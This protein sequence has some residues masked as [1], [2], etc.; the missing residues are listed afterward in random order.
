MPNNKTYTIAANATAQ[1]DIKDDFGAND[2]TT[3]RIKLLPDETTTQPPI[4]PSC[5]VKTKQTNSKLDTI[6]ATLTTTD[7]VKPCQAQ[8]G[9]ALNQSPM[10]CKPGSPEGFE[11]KN[12]INHQIKVRIEIV[13]IT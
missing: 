11:L 8:V 1:A 12:L 3:V 4:I 5:Q 7:A 6:D 9:G 13:D 2:V 10:N